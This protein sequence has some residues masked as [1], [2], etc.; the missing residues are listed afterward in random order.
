MKGISER[1]TSEVM[2]IL[3][4]LKS[5]LCWCDYF[6]WLIC[7]LGKWYWWVWVS[8]LTPPPPQSVLKFDITQQGLFG[9]SLKL[10][11]CF[12]TRAHQY[13][14][15]EEIVWHFWAVLLVAPLLLCNE[16][17]WEDGGGCV[18]QALQ[19]HRALLKILVFDSQ[20]SVSADL[21]S[22]CTQLDLFCNSYSASQIISHN[23]D[24][25]GC[26]LPQSH[27]PLIK[28]SSQPA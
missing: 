18:I 24:L 22:L 14:C 4:A 21:T 17:I 1:V 6:K 20:S 8:S 16:S 5:K 7:H 10:L 2:R 25:S 3:R 11:L 23:E 12:P 9:A 28:M 27:L 13:M 15:K 26:L 19:K